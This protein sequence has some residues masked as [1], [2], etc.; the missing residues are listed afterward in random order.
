MA[1]T[2]QGATARTVDKNATPEKLAPATEVEASGAIIE[3]AIAQGVDMNHPAVDA[4]PRENS[5]PEM[6]QID[7][8]DPTKTPE[9]AV[10]DNLGAPQ[11]A[12]ED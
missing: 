2:K 6:N 8:N 3:P 1:I 7:F 12:D 5:T 11:A 9:Q 4:N 10:A